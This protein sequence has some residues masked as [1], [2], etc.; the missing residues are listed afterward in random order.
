METDG[1]ITDRVQARH[2][3]RV[4]L[5]QLV[6][7]LRDERRVPNRLGGARGELAVG[8]YSVVLGEVDP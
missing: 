6:F 4:D 7:D 1:C 5:T 8:K 3:A 2:D